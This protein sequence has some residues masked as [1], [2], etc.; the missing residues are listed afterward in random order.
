MNKESDRDPFYET[1]AEYAYKVHDYN[2]LP[3]EQS[4]FRHGLE[5][6]AFRKGTTLFFDKGFNLDTK[7]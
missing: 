3:S 7:N 2:S 4:I 6:N 1:N 5:S